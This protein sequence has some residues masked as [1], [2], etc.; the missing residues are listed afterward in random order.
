[1]EILDDWV[2]QKTLGVDCHYGDDRSLTNFILKNHKMKYSSEAR[3]STI[4]PDT[5]RQ[6]LRQQL[7]WKK[8]WIVESFR[9]GL[10]IWRKNPLIAVSFYSDIFLT[11]LSPVILFEALVWD[12]LVN[13]TSPHIFLAGLVLV[14]FV[15]GYYYH[16]FTGNKSWLWGVVAAWFYAI[17]MIFQM[18]YAL[19]TLRDTRWG[20][21]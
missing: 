12:P 21:R 7:R 3:A 2:Y 8:S 15:Y 18:P 16:I 4:V 6:F 13:N 17:V 10:F 11:I 14:S 20:T 1:L 9:A 5:T 19:L